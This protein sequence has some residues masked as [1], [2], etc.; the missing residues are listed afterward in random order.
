M[1]SKYSVGA[2][3]VFT[4][5]YSLRMRARISGF[6]RFSVASIAIKTRQKIWKQYSTKGNERWMEAMTCSC[7]LFINLFVAYKSLFSAFLQHKLLCDVPTAPPIFRCLTN[8]HIP[9]HFYS[10][11][12]VLALL[13]LRL[14][15][16]G[17]ESGKRSA[18]K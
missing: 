18:N 13:S 14:A 1:D 3:G 12:R 7:H 16:L 4:I 2:V 9:F 17:L 10:L 6:K 8:L 15:S 5:F 11:V